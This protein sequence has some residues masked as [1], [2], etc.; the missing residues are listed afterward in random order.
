MENFRDLLDIR[1]SDKVPNAW[2]KQLCGMTKGVD[3]K[4]DEVYKEEKR[5]IKSCIYIGAMRR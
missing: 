1:R 2:I 3:K 4:I 5:E